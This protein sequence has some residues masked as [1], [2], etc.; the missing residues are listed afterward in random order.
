MKPLS[1][2]ILRI[3]LLVLIC[4]TDGTT[5]LLDRGKTYRDQIAGICQQSS[6]KAKNPIY[7][8]PGLNK[9]KALEFHDGMTVADVIRSAGGIREPF[10]QILILRPSAKNPNPYW[11]QTV[12]R[13]KLDR[14]KP[15]GGVG[16]FKFR[17]RAG[18]IVEAWKKIEGGF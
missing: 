4:V 15:D 14:T 18:D 9:P 2:S 6:C 1:R 5:M 10:D 8:G 13:Y 7:A 17:L 12:F 3:A 16:A 11:G